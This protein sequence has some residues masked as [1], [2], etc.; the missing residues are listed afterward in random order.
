M[1]PK[2]AGN[3]V[4]RI[5]AVKDKADVLWIYGADDVAV[6]NSAASDPGTWG[7]TGRL[8]GFPGAE[9]YP[10]QPMMEQIRVLLKAYAEAGGHYQETA[11]KGSGHV[12][13]ITHQD[14]FNEVFHA[15]LERSR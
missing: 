13:F 15:F 12:P 8:P 1:S 5:L 4:D 11:I 9:R 7:P 14:E 3:L 6:S 10:P 2:Y